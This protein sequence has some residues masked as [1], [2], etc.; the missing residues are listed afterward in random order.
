MSRSGYS[1]EGDYYEL[2][3][4]NVERTIASKKGQTFLKEL[5]QLMDA[6]PEKKLI[7]NELINEKGE[8]CT[9]G[10]FCKAKNIDVTGIDVGDGDEVGRAVGITGM[11]AR[12]IEYM[13]DEY[14]W[15]VETPEQRWER[16]RKWV[17]KNI[18]KMEENKSE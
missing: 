7:A 17:D 10:V 12:E 3:R 18:L 8:C 2:Y 6:M 15:K 1:D 9:I 16:M 4:A 14:V 5:A 11:L 13:N